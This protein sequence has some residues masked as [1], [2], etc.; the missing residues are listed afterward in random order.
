MQ[1]LRDR[2]ENVD[3]LTLRGSVRAEDNNALAEC[4]NGLR[5]ERRFRLVIDVTDLE[6]I[7]SR[8]IG[9]VVRFLQE[10]RPRGGRVVLVRP[11]QPIEK[12]MKAVGL[13][14]LVQVF[15]TLEEAVAACEA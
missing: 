9:E 15:D 7:N 6:Y 12:I 11:R 1:L 10:A 13:H 2:R 3:V 14:S 8:G 4:L 5:E